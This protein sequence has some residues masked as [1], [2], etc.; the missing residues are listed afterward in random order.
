[1]LFLMRL[2]KTPACAS[3][4]H[5]QAVTGFILEHQEIWRPAQLKTNLESCDLSK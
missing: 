4:I 1:M 5:Q 2:L 3:P